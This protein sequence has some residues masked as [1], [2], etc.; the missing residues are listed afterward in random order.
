MPALQ[1]QIPRLRL[2][3][4]SPDSSQTVRLAVFAGQIVVLDFFAYWCPP[5]RTASQALESEIQR[6]YAARNGNLQAIVHSHRG[7]AES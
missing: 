3:M 6:F 4:T 1:Q 5:C 2:G 7:Y